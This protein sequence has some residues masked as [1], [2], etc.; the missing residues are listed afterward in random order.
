MC[1]VVE[2]QLLVDAKMC[3]NV[4][5]EESSLYFSGVVEGW[6]G[7]VPLGKVINSDNNVLV[8]T[9]VGWSTLDEVNS[10]LAKGTFSDD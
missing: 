9:T 7:F 8:A 6:H 4:V 2:D 5:E 3:D 10:P 1:L